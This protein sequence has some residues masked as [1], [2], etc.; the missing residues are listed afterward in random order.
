MTRFE[1]IL[2]RLRRHEATLPMLLDEL[3]AEDGDRPFLTSD[4]GRL[5]RAEFAARA[6]RLA[7]GLRGLGVGAG[8]RVLVV[9]ENHPAHPLTLFACG[10]IGAI[11]TP[12][13]P[14]FR[15]AELAYALGHCEPA[16]VIVAPDCAAELREA[17]TQTGADIPVIALGP[18]VAGAAAEFD[19]L[20]AVPLP[21]PAMAETPQETDACCIIYTSGT[22]GNPKGVLH[23]H[24]NYVI[25]GLANIRRLDLTEG[26]VVMVI[27]PF[28]HVNALFYSL[29][30]AIAARASVVLRRRFSASAF[31]TDCAEHGATTVNIIESVAAI[32]LARPQAEFRPDHRLRIVYG[33]RAHFEQAIQSRFAIPATVTGFG[34]TEV[35]GVTCTRPGAENLPGSMGYPIAFPEE[36]ALSVQCR[37][38][39]DAGRPLPDG[40]LGEF[41]IRAPTLMTGY[42][43]DPEATRAAYTGDGWLKT[44]DLVRR[45]PDGCF[46]YVS[47][48]KDIIRRRGENIA[49][50]EI[51]TLLRG[52]DAIAEA[53]AIA[54]PSEM[55][56]DDIMAVLLPVPGAAPSPAEIA[57]WCRERISRI[58]VPRYYAFVEEMPLTATHKI[59]KQ[60]LRA[61]ADLR[62]RAFDIEQA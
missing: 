58:K 61:D 34:M 25:G 6:R 3:A 53:A 1:T 17:M 16:A 45:Q 52:H 14:A 31:W 50:A 18:G 57:A 21:E 9:S 40:E 19:A 33:V 12:V 37:V 7:A 62:A 59:A 5:S 54:V 20:L 55:G 44:G 30:G 29:A 47:R 49:A 46:V 4:A 22:T 48:K 23:S 43:R 38:A 35:P 11:F 15:R 2:D 13:N 39:D 32:L 27:L 10:C 26:D 51:E 56:E 8:D 41:Q 42:F 24:R 28:F 60:V 36:P